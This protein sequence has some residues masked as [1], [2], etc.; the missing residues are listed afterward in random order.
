MKR[1]VMV[2]EDE[3]DIL[4]LV[5]AALGDD[6]RYDLLIARDGEEALELA[7]RKRPALLFLDLLMPKMDGYTVCRLLR[8]DPNN[9]HMKIVVM[10]A[11]AQEQDRSR[12]L[13]AG[14][15]DYIT[16]PFKV[17]HLLEKVDEALNAHGGEGQGCCFTL[18]SEDGART[19]G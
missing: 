10:T 12:A 19:T 9:G 16:K 1:R 2:A 5:V 6:E 18:E 7:R 14:A 13:E 4:A 8:A 11:L 15:D 3:A 17:A